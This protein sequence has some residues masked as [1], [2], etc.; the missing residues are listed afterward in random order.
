MMGLEEYDE[1]YEELRNKY[2][3]LAKYHKNL[4]T[5][6]EKLSLEHE[7]LKVTHK[8]LEC[9]LNEKAP[10]NTPS[11]HDGS[12]CVAKVD[13]STSCLDLLTIPCTSSYDDM[14]T[15]EANLLKENEK[16]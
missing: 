9:S 6:H 15:L 14:S 13:A 4:L 12:I 5:R 1:S 10:S 11:S 8:E 7:E 16:L 2:E 3:T